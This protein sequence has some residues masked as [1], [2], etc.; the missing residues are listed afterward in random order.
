MTSIEQNTPGEAEE[1]RPSDAERQTIKVEEYAPSPR[2]RARNACETS[3]LDLA[4]Q[5]EEVVLE[6][7]AT[8]EE[9]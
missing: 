5:A 1:Y 6:D 8:G 2:V 7:P 9:L 4:E 3:L